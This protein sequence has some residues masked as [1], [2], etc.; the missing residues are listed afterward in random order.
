MKTTYTTLATLIILVMCFGASAQAPVTML[1]TTSAASAQSKTYNATG[2][3]ASSFSSKTFT[4]KFGA[5]AQA[6]DHVKQLDSFTIGGE[7]YSYVQNANSYVKLRRVNNTVVNTNRQLLWVEKAASATDKTI[8]VVNPYDEN[9]ESVF[10][11]NSLSQ[12]TDNLFANQ[13][14]GNG[15]NNNIERLDVIFQGGIIAESNKK[16]GFALF[17]RGADNA[18]DPFVIAAISAVDVDGNP[19]AYGNP[20]RVS[21]T[22]WGNIPA[23]TINYYV[24]R[25]DPATEPN[26]R[27]STSGTQNIGGVFVSL[28]DLGVDTDTKIY[29][30]SI[31]AYDLPA[32]ATSANLVDYTNSN[33]F[34]TNTSSATSQGGIDLIALTGV[35]SL[36]QQVILPPV[37]N[38]ILMPAMLNTAPQT[39]L[40]PL[41]AIA[42]SGTIAYYTIETISP[43]EKG[44][45]YLCTNNNCIAVT[46][47]QQLTPDQINQLAFAPNAAYAGGEVVFYYNATDSYNQ[48]S[49]SASY[50]IPVI[51]QTFG[52]LPVILTSFNA[53]ADKKTIRLSWHTAQEVN[54]SYFEVQRSNDG[55][56]F[57]PVA[58]LTAAGK[59]T[60]GADYETTDDLFF[61]QNSN[62]FYRLKMVD[63]DG[64]SKY[65]TVLMLK[66]NTTAA[67]STIK[68]WPNP[69][70]T[71]LNTSVQSNT[72]EVIKIK[73]I[74]MEGKTVAENAV[75]VQKGNNTLLVPAAAG[76]TKGAY[77][78]QIVTGDKTE[79]VRIIKQ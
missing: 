17:E 14:D 63:V 30:Y 77:I 32:S 7:T 65:S 5:A 20:L 78:L 66:L 53:S 58:T 24:V 1:N 42:A 44:T 51:A 41:E 9:M 76:I 75:R 49:N 28:N 62:V 40:L 22:Q 55:K 13:G 72:N 21:A 71:Q 70:S 46:E 11:G 54:S 39:G 68:A 18:H 10:S 67:A 4:Y 36:P 34:P 12:G 45:L 60:G 25:R 27:M 57:E 29:G 23:S 3:N 33:F 16:V 50:T 48:V 31:I 35:L 64:K 73:L 56:T 47:G 8:A 61:Y 43:T 2:A 15:N 59:L 79:N 26:L 19:T 69:Y 52:P 74:N 38:N 6:T 37:A